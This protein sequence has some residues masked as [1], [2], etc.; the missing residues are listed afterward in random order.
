MGLA[1]FPDGPYLLIRNP[2]NLVR[3]DSL[4]PLSFDVVQ[5]LF[6]HKTQLL[7]DSVR[8]LIGT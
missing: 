5:Q 4:I 7:A 3:P 8:H 1:D 6:F 2:P